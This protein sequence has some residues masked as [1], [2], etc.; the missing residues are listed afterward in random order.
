MIKSIITWNNISK[1]CLPS[2]ILN[3]E[4]IP[5]SEQ[6]FNEQ[7]VHM[8]EHLR[9]DLLNELG[10][11]IPRRMIIDKIK[12][13]NT[14]FTFKY[15]DECARLGMTTLEKIPNE[16]NYQNMGG[17]IA[18]SLKYETN[19]VII[20]NTKILFDINNKDKINIQPILDKR[21]VLSL[22]KEKKKATKKQISFMSLIDEIT[23]KNRKDL[24]MKQMSKAKNIWEKWGKIDHY[25]KS[26]S[27]DCLLMMMFVSSLEPFFNQLMTISDDNDFYTSLSNTL[28][29]DILKKKIEL[30][31][32]EINSY[33]DQILNGSIINISHFRDRIRGLFGKIK[34]LN[35][36]YYNTI[37]YYPIF[38][39]KDIIKL[40]NKKYSSYTRL[41]RYYI[42]KDE[43]LDYSGTDGK[44]YKN[45][46]VDNVLFET[47]EEFLSE[48]VIF[49]IDHALLKYLLTRNA[50]INY[51]DYVATG[52]LDEIKYCEKCNEF[53]ERTVIRNHEKSWHKNNKIDIQE[54][55][56]VQIDILNSDWLVSDGWKTKKIGDTNV[57]YKTGEEAN[58][59]RYISESDILEMENPPAIKYERHV[60]NMSIYNA[61][62]IIFDFNRKLGRKNRNT[63][64]WE[65]EY[66]EELPIIPNE[67]IIDLMGYQY[68]LEVIITN[69]NNLCMLF[70]KNDKTWLC[71]NSHYNVENTSDY[72]NVIGN[73]EKLL[74]Y[75]D[76]FVSKHGVLYIY[77]LVNVQ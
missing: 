48:H 34:L 64:I 60:D 32:D 19:N 38:F 67:N 29:P 14:T 61:E 55:M 10:I 50:H 37:N 72:I 63:L 52:R 9:I 77:K 73:Y 54:L 20:D 5:I 16:Y 24:S 44:I 59:D 30:F 26:S 3:S 35:K 42:E 23:Q 22:T 25:Q 62:L 46:I 57:F 45:P 36:P 31:L 12:Q 68:T 18:Q 58:I 70:L 71:Y 40:F 56:T 11:Q 2:I 33:K 74:E 65:P 6:W 7:L 15:C 66:Y 1:Y 13:R 69:R 8:A 47:T 28:E 4:R 53:Y 27:L 49:T 17:K 43:V 75:K 41:T 51:D 21:F 39:L 76:K